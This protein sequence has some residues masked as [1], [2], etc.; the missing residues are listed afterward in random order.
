MDIEDIVARIAS[1]NQRIADEQNTLNKIFG[2]SLIIPSNK[3]NA[4]IIGLVFIVVSSIVT[5][6]LLFA[7]CWYLDRPI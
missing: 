1:D 2:N 7:W 4:L 6:S 3:I 5:L